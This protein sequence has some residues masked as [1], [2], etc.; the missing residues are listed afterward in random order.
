MDLKT[1][2]STRG[3]NDTTLSHRLAVLFER[4]EH[5]NELLLL[6]LIAPGAYLKQLKR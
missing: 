3:V 2:L 5:Q 1:G 6:S 4:S